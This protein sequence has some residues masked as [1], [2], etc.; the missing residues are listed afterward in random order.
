[1]QQPAISDERV[2]ANRQKQAQT[3]M[4]L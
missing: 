1:V 3:P 4:T 2:R